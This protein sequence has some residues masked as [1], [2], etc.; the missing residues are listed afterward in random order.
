MNETI[1]TKIV[2][3]K[4]SGFGLTNRTGSAGPVGNNDSEIIREFQVLRET[5]RVVDENLVINKIMLA[6]CLDLSKTIN[7]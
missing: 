3:N 5:I 6:L 2:P 7:L 1:I 4:W